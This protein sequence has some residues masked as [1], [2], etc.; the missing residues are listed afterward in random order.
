MSPAVIY[1][2]KENKVKMVVGGS[3]GSRIISAV[4]QVV[5]RALVFNQTV[6]EAID[7]P[8]FHNQFAPFM[9]EYEDKVPHVSFF[10]LNT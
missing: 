5:I 9:T 10:N 4:A 8:R 3:G 1:D 7:A 2:K 6:K